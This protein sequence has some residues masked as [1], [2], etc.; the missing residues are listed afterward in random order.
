MSKETQSGRNNSQLRMPK[1]N[2]P[3]ITPSN[4]V[5]RLIKVQKEVTAQCITPDQNLSI[6]L[7]PAQ[8]IKNYFPRFPFFMLHLL[9][10][11][12]NLFFISLCTLI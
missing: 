7:N 6:T 8:N 1:I 2:I 11:S 5:L 3:I 4:Y 10:S 9:Y 12:F